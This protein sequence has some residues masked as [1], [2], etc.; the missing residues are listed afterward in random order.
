LAPARGIETFCCYFGGERLRERPLREDRESGKHTFPQYALNAEPAEFPMISK[1]AICT[2]IAKNYL[3]FARTLC[4]SFR[5]HNPG[6]PCYVLVIDEWEPFIKTE[7][8]PFELIS[9]SDLQISE[10]I[11][12]AFRY[13]ITEFSTAVKPYLIAHLFASKG[14]SRL[15]YLDPD[16]LVTHSLAGLFDALDKHDYILTPHLDADYPDDNYR[17]SDGDILRC[18]IFNLGFLGI[19]QNDTS[20]AFLK[21]WQRKLKTKC[22]DA[23]AAGYFVDQRFIDLAILLYPGSFAGVGFLEV[24]RR[25]SV[26]F[27]FQRLQS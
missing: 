11:D 15:L 1:Q 25:S 26:F 5:A 23:P 9:L 10:V 19:R 2:I 24:Q 18:G 27:P 8:E 6:V 7:E 14:V 17:P 4:Y 12:M 21:W 20:A 3:S 13:D 22:V 16:I